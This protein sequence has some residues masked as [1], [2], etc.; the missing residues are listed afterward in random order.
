[1]S[2]LREQVAYAISHG[3]LTQNENE[4]TAADLIG[5]LAM[6]DPLGAALWRVTGNLDPVAFRRARHL[7][8][9]EVLGMNTK[10]PLSLLGRVCQLS[11][12]EWLACLCS[13]CGGRAFVTS[14]S[15]VRSTCKACKGTGRGRQTDE[16]R[17]AALHVGKA[18]YSK[19]VAVIERAH[20]VLNAAD[21][22]VSRQIAQQ[23][24]RKVPFSNVKSK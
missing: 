4:E 2:G 16:A 6:A 21:R 19:L 8:L 24:E 17:M 7:L 22:R 15:G 3:N 20:E 12:E 13:T 23:L 14:A 5:A 18:T 10:Q 1:M 9:T 11:M